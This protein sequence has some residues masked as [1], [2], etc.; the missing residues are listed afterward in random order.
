MSKVT[1]T[2]FY[3]ISSNF[4]GYPHIFPHIPKGSYIKD[5]RKRGGRGDQAKADTCG[6]GGRRGQAKLDVHIW[7]KFDK[8]L[9]SNLS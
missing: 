9:I 8:Y 3:L 1:L 2:V 6:H 7:F 4:F 5:V